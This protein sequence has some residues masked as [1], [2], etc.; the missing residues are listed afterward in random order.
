[1][2]EGGE[3]FVFDMGDSVKIV[4]LAK[5]MVRLSG[6]ELGKDV[7]I[8]YTGLRPGEKLYE[9][10]LNKE[11]NTKPTYHHKI[12]IANIKTYQIDQVTQSIENFKAALSKQDSFELV[13]ILKAAIPEYK[14][15]NSEF[16]SLDVVQ[17]T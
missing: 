1:M 16:S 12:L 15:E 7:Q 6:L 5:K 3:I 4:D 8:Q 14:S 9:E 11:E 13:G 17:M 2:G 10:L